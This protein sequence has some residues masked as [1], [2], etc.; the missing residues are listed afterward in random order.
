MKL[1]S[2]SKNSVLAEF[3]D[4]IDYKHNLCFSTPLYHHEFVCTDE[5]LQTIESWYW[6]NV[7]SDKD[8]LIEPEFNFDACYDI[9]G[10][11][12]VSAW[13]DGFD[14]EDGEIIGTTYGR[15]CL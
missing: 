8:E 5:A 3:E 1:H 6:N 15:I 13:S 7:R 2:S 12:Y 9:P 11:M 14:K 10:M 4:G